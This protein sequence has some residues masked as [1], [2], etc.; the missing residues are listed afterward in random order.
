MDR[1]LT[2]SSTSRVRLRP[3][4]RADEA[5]FLDAC[6]ASRSL[7]ETWVSPPRTTDDFAKYVR[8]FSGR[9]R[10]PDHAGYLAVHDDDGALAGVFNFSQIARGALQSAYLGFYAFARYAGRGLMTEGLVLALDRAFGHHRLHRVEVNVRPENARSI[11]LVDR[12]G[13]ER[14]GYSR[15]YLKLAGRWRDHVRYAM[16][17][18]DWSAKRR[19]ALA[20]LVQSDK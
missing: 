5:A 10:D 20:S 4:R 3:P 15:R 17:T 7:H 12:I 14:E 11:A 16:L 8:R 19:A 2:R 13:F 18:E 6:A 1:S 9:G